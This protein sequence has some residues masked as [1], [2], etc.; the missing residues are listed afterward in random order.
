MNAT[1][2]ERPPLPGRVAFSAQSGGLG[3]ALLGELAGR[4]LGISSFASLGNKADVSGNDLLR[5]WEKDPE[6]DVILLYLESFGNPRKFSR[7]ARRV[8]HKTPI[9]AVKSARTPAGL[10]GVHAPSGRG[11]PTRPPTPSSARPG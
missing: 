1:F 11:C 3:I 8:A 2:A 9:V 5:F 10:R 7:I 4:G 6:T